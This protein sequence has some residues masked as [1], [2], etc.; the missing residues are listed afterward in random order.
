VPELPEVETTRRGIAPHLVGRHV[1]QLV[2]RTRKLRWP[3]PPALPETL[4]GQAILDVGRR[5]KYL[6]LHT[7][8]GTVL[9]HL[10]MSGSLRVLP[11]HVAPG[12]HDHVDLVLDS[13]KALRF[14]DPR[15]FGF[16]LWQPS[17]FTHDLLAE[18]GPE[19]LGD[20]FDGDHLWRLSRGRRV[21]VK[22][23]LM[24]QRVVVGVGNIYAAEALFKAGI[25]PRRAAGRVA[26]ERYRML[27]D[28][29]RDVLA[30]SIRK[31]GTTIRDYVDSDGQPGWFELE[32][33]V[34]GREGE[35]CRVCRATIKSLRLGQRASCYCPKCQK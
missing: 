35:P 31:G 28:A 27:A 21:A 24:D 17:G 26:R 9:V 13:G 32:L 3:V 22:N 12:R 15:R 33:D 7:E 34:Y 30:R 25:D 20:E 2:L 1:R 11:K 16:W 19:P 29:V 14:N 10:G 8:P 4:R 18:L 6:L 5:A 23:F